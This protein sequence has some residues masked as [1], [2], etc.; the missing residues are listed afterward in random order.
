MK[1]PAVF[2]DRDNTLIASDGYLSNPAEVRLI[3]GAADAVARARSLGFATI[4]F[5][6]QSGVARG[7][8]DEHAVHAVNGRLDEM[9]HDQNPLAVIDRHEFCP[10]H[11]EA[12][13]EA[14]R[15]ES[16]LRKPGPG[17]ILQ[18]GEK[19]ALDLSRSWAIGDAPRDIQAGHAAGCRT[20]LFR[21]PRL[22]PSPAAREKPVVEPDY[23]VGTLKEAISI[24]ESASQR[25][26][27]PETT[28]KER[29]SSTMRINP[30]PDPA[31]FPTAAD[32]P[33]RES[34]TLASPEISSPSVQ[35]PAPPIIPATATAGGSDPLPVAGL[36]N[37][38][39]M[40]RQI[41]AELRRGHEQ[42][43]AEFSVSKLLAGIVQV[44]VLAVLFLAYLHRG[45]A[46]IQTVLI[47]ALVL[48]TM[49]IALLVMGKQH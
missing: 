6:N 42:P 8:F 14:Y 4:I 11:P 34:Q 36:S 26:A 21:D 47:F 40:G 37:L 35:A 29:D 38:E 2:F 17:M 30:S 28:E 15:Q 33:D 20:I 24:I 31:S 46:D 5:S 13:V 45:D 43:H 48:Q 16:D 22:A 49:T 25:P 7:L 44:I 10:F 23:V 3:D 27:E 1:R 12:S 9:L 41:L 18:A 32:A 19:L 39:T